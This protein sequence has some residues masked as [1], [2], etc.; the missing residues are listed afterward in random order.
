MNRRC[1]MSLLGGGALLQPMA[2]GAQSAMRSSNS[3]ARSD[4]F[5]RSGGAPLGSSVRN[6]RR[7]EAQAPSIQDSTCAARASLLFS[8]I[9]M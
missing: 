1:F 3:G 2:T 7:G 9:I 5:R 4:R 6:R 8:S